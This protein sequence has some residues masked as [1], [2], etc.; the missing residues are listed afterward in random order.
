MVAS[1][2]ALI[3]LLSESVHHIRLKP[4]WKTD[5]HFLGTLLKPLPAS[6][7]RAAPSGRHGH[8]PWALRWPR[9]RSQVLVR[10]GSR[11][12][13]CELLGPLPTC[14]SP[15]LLLDHSQPDGHSSASPFSF[16]FHS[17]SWRSVCTCPS[18]HAR[19]RSS[20]AS[21]RGRK[22]FLQGV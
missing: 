16:S 9:V 4:E 14:L 18:L 1:A 5:A 10:P 8:L 11:Q 13:P 15:W 22:V 7:S 21:G 17:T 3:A 6:G 20:R 19:P 12:P 2:V